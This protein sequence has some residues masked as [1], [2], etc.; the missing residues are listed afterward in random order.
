MM[1]AKTN[2]RTSKKE[3]VADEVDSVLVITRRILKQTVNPSMLTAEKTEVREDWTPKSHKSY[4]HPSN[5]NKGRESPATI[6]KLVETVPLNSQ[7]ASSNNRHSF[8]ASSRKA[9][10]TRTDWTPKIHKSYDHPFN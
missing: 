5:S 1:S 9:R 8:N 3:K 6:T 10:R 7:Y 4:D 2:E